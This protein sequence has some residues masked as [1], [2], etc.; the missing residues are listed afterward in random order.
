MDL[1]DVEVQGL[2]HQVL[3]VLVNINVVELGKNTEQ[4]QDLAHLMNVAAEDDEAP[5]DHQ[6]IA[7]KLRRLR[8]TESAVVAKRNQAQI[9]AVM[10]IAFH[11]EQKKAEANLVCYKQQELLVS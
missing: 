1:R 5:V 7:L 4:D 8:E 9:L 3:E 10:Q 2:H 6:K 11:W